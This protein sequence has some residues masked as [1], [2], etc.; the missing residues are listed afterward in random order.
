MLLT[1]FLLYVFIM[2]FTP[3]PNNIMSMS[4]ANKY[5]Y[6]NTLKFIFGVGTG[7]LI[8]MLVCSYFNLVLFKIIPKVNFIMSIIGSIYMLYLAIKM[9]KSKSSKNQ[10]VKEK[11]HSFFSG[12]V[13]QFINPK[14]ILFG[15][16]VFSSFIM[17]NY[18]SNSSLILFSLFLALLG[19]IAPL[20]WAFFGVLFQKF[21]SKYERSF[22][23]TMSV[24]LVY[25][26]ISIFI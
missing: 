4:Y 13:L 22:N 8:L 14:G 7:F 17:P 19:F 10:Q 23:M 11:L 16:T 5:G 25:S 15:L 1:P 21:L 2:I 26:A 24:L 20:C 12:M 18:K 6:Q 9:I 3:G